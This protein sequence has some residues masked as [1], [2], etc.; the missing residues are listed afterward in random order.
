M[1]SAV[2]TASLRIN[3]TAFGLESLRIII[4]GIAYLHYFPDL[5]PDR[6]AGSGHQ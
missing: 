5:F 1:D 6:M 3:L 2:M 4:L